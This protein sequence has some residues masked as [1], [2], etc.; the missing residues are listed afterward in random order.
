MKHYR[1][2]KI[3]NVSKS[4]QGQKQQVAAEEDWEP[5]E[6]DEW[7]PDTGDMNEYESYLEKTVIQLRNII[8]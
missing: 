6:D 5:T 1:T 4:D 8:G 7:R 2:E 3:E